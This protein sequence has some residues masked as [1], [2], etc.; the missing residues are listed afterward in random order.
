M[1]TLAPAPV[2]CL[3][4]GILSSSACHLDILSYGKTAL[5][6]LCFR[7]CLLFVPFYLFLDL[8]DQCI[9]LISSFV[10][11][12]PCFPGCLLYVTRFVSWAPVSSL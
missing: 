7:L 10:F 6:V 12:F 3:D 8:V 11:C 2:P 4:F 5:L 9:V 1:T